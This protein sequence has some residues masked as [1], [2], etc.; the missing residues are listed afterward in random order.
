MRLVVIQGRFCFGALL[1]VL[2]FASVK[3]KYKS[4]LQQG[5]KLNRGKKPTTNPRGGSILLETFNL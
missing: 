5:F 1:F 4:A 2:I 3:I